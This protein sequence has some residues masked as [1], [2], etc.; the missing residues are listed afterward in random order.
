MKRF[1]WIFALLLS[2]A[3]A[4]AQ[5]PEEALRE[6]GMGGVFATGDLAL[7]DLDPST[8]PVLQLKRFFAEAKLPLTTD[9]QKRLEAIIEA[10]RK[11]M[12]SN[13]Q[14]G[15]STMRMNMEFMRRINGVLT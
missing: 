15:E 7:R 8:D 14:G 4:F 2:A 6:L 10:Q 9:Q 12:H 13:T 11:A 1:V 3:P 5:D